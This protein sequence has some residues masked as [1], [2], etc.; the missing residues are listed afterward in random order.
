MND[1]NSH[2]RLTRGQ[3]DALWLAVA[4]V[5]AGML[6]G[7]TSSFVTLYGAASAQHWRFPAL[8]PLGIDSGILAYVVL[9]HIAITLGARSRW[10]HLAAAAIAAFTVWANAAVAPASSDTWRAIHA[11]M[12]ALWVLGVEALRFTWRRL[13]EPENRADVIPRARWLA[14]PVRTYGMQRRMILHN[15]ASYAEASAREDA[16]VLGMDLA[17]AVFGKQWKRDA[18]ALLRHHLLEGTL[19]ADVAVA[20]ADGSRELPDAVEAWITGASSQRDKA[21]ARA[22]QEKRAI[23]APSVTPPR[24][25]RPRAGKSSRPTAAE[26]DKRNAVA[27]QLLTDNP[28]MLRKDVAAE[29]GVS[30]R[31]VDRLR[32]EMGTEP[33][34]L[35]LAA[36]AGG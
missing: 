35:H 8:L 34:R 27:R 33:R 4:L 26:R 11:A 10:L 7:F 22:R 17:A 36:K 9:D 6:I 32:G 30:E 29:S 24:A 21:A 3:R 20:A 14:A 16:R 1:V 5:I 15:V 23:D 2:A 25:P 12:P 19:P 18:P 31:T 13:H 28:A